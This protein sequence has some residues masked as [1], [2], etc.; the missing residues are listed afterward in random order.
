MHAPYLPPDIKKA[1]TTVGSG[2]RLK[3]ILIYKI[4]KKLYFFIHICYNRKV[5]QLQKKGI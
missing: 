2:I 3:N 4:A 1:L 5:I